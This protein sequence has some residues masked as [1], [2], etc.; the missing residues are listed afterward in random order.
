MS[1]LPFES[2][3]GC[4][5]RAGSAVCGW[6]F[7]LIWSSIFSCLSAPCLSALSSASWP[8]TAELSLSLPT[9]CGYEMAVG[10]VKTGQGEEK[11]T[12]SRAG[13]MKHTC[14]GTTEEVMAPSGL[15]QLSILI[16]PNGILFTHQY[17][18]PLYI[19][20]GHGEL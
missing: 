4:V 9:L 20:L 2:C 5:H 13:L 15:N 3:R 12:E 17:T 19:P 10:S 14:R 1:S 18:Q 6:T 16:L 8:I 11:R 7:C